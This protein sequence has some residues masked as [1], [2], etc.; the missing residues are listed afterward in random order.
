MLPHRKAG[1]S[2]VAGNGKR[3]LLQSIK[4]VPGTLGFH[5]GNREETPTQVCVLL[6]RKLECIKL[7]DVNHEYW[8]VSSIILFQREVKVP[9]PPD[10]CHAR[11]VCG[12]GG[13]QGGR[14]V[15]GHWS[16]L[17]STLHYSR[18]GIKGAPES[19]PLNV[20]SFFSPGNIFFLC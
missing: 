5:T 1:W 6:E 2:R 13:R 3:S 15:R 14:C 7:L 4:C 16:G 11:C 8:T 19:Y 18:V 17:G 9:C 12:R 20:F 10:E